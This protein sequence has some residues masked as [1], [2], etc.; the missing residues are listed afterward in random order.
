MLEGATWLWDPARM[1]VF[2]LVLAGVGVGGWGW[3]GV[4]W[5]GGLGWS[6]IV[7]PAGFGSFSEM[8]CVVSSVRVGLMGAKR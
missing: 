3:G 1:V 4:G 5:G 2:P 8:G 7:L 6:D